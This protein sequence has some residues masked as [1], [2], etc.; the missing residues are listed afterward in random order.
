MPGPSPALGSA[1]CTPLL[2]VDSR[3]VD[4]FCTLV[5]YSPSLREGSGGQSPPVLAFSLRALGLVSRKYDVLVFS[6]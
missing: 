6:V 3:F 1:T 2:F 5:T 4:Y